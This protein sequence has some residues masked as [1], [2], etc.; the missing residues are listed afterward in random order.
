M[1]VFATSDLH[2]DYASNAEWVDGLSR[3]EYIDDVLMVAGDLSDSLS[4]LARSLDALARRF[5]KV[6]FVPGNHELWV[7]RDKNGGTSLD[8]FE[9]VCSVARSCGVMTAPVH[10]GRV[11]IVP[12]FGWYDDSFGVPCEELRGMWADF[13]T[14]RWPAG[15]THV[16]ATTHFCAMNEA[17]LSVRNDTVI[18]FSHFLPRIDLMPAYIP[19]K[20]RVLYPVLGTTRLEQQ[21]RRLMPSIHVYGHSHVNRDRTIDGVR[22]VNNAFAYPQ[23]HHLAA[24]QLVCVH[25]GPL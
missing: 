10:L 1:R 24:K 9:Q 15:W 8:K 3:S 6:L 17:W 20:F 23:E 4:R 2:V 19:P 21:L 12:L 5:K 22:Y 13:A 11:S 18:S 16:H 25:E 7:H 14:C